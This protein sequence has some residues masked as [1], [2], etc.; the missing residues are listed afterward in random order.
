M[1]LLREIE[2]HRFEQVVAAYERELGNAAEL[3]DF[4]PDGGVDVRVFDQG[5]R[6]PKRI[7]Q[8]KAHSKPIGVSLVRE[9][10]GVMILQKIQQGTFYTT[11]SYS[12]D[13][14]ATFQSAP[15]LELIN[16]STFLN[17]IEALPVSAQLRLFDVA[18]EGD[19]TTPTC[20]SCGVK[21][22]TKTFDGDLAEGKW[23]CRNFPRCKQHPMTKKAD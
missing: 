10:L 21:M 7:I 12:D 19:Y 2:W 9:F 14:L 1:A 16:G 6:T 13:A 22:I 4:G 5:S 17:L 18:T 3:T 8:C 20:P 11:G 15:A 23:V